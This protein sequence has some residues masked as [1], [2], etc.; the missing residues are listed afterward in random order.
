M[1]ETIAEFPFIIPEQYVT[2]VT[3]C[4]RSARRQCSGPERPSPRSPN[5]HGGEDVVGPVGVALQRISPLTTGSRP[6]S[7]RREDSSRPAYRPVALGLEQQLPQQRR[8]GHAGHGAFF[9][10]WPSSPWD[11]RRRA[12]SWRQAPSA[13]YCPPACLPASAP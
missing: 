8:H 3:Y 12:A 1:A 5:P 11:S 10:P 6:A 4:W 2:I 9:R 13:A 7:C